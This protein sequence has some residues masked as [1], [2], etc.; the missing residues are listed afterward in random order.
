MLRLRVLSTGIDAD[1]DFKARKSNARN[2]RQ[3]DDFE[4]RCAVG[5]VNRVIHQRLLAI[6]QAGRDLSRFVCKIAIESGVFC[7]RIDA[8]WQD[9]A[10]PSSEGQLVVRACGYPWGILTG[11][12]ALRHCAIARNFGGPRPAGGRAI[13]IDEDRSTPER[14]TEFRR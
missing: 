13:A 7:N 2:K 4:V 10:T 3:N 9:R 14:P 1:P 8:E 11:D 5:T 6:V 12:R